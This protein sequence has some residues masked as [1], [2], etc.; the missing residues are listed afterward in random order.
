MIAKAAALPSDDGGGLHED[1]YVAPPGPSLREPTPKHSVGRL[2][3]RSNA[4]VLVHGQL[5]A[6]SSHLDRHGGARANEACECGHNG[7]QNVLHY[8]P[9]QSTLPCWPRSPRF[10]AHRDSRESQPQR[11]FLVCP[12]TCASLFV[13]P[14][15]SV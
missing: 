8:Q 15:S 11:G 12:S 7:N 3:A 1:E 4:G 2:D 14:P 13:T 5:M 6:Q 9:R 10:R